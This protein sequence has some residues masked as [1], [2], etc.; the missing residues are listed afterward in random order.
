VK[1]KTILSAVLFCLALSLMAWCQE[2]LDNNIGAVGIS[3]QPGGSPAIAGSAMYMK[4]ASASTGTYAFSLFD[5]VPTG[6]KPFTVQT[7]V[8]AGMAQRLV[9]VNGIPIYVPLTAGFSYSGAN[10]GW[11]W[12]SGA[13]AVIPVSIHGKASS[14]RILPSIRAVKSSVSGGTGYQ[15]IAGA[16]VGWG[17]N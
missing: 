9:T 3:Y 5:A 15:L 1:T 12:S 10:S 6:V 2:P 4:L 14:W 7:A 17:W 8:G 16:Q 13:F 11:A